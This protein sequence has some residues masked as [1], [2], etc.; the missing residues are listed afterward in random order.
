MVGE[1]RTLGS[2]VPIN[3]IHAAL[4]RTGRVLLVAGSENDATVTTY[5]ASVWDPATGT[6]ATQ[7]VPWDLFCNA[8]TFLPDGR[9]LTVGGNL[10]YNPFRGIR[11]TTVFDPS[12]GAVQ[13]ASRHGARPVVPVECRPGRRAHDDL[14]GLDGNGRHQRR[15][16]ALHG[17]RRLERGVHGAVHAA[18]LSVAAPA[19]RRARVRVRPSDRLAHLRSRDADLDHQRRPGAL[20]ERADVRLIGAPAPAS[21]SRA[22]ARGS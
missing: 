5:R 17:A 15:G 14:L 2:T 19:A 20:S 7:T 13:P 11:T 1:W 10:Q 21:G 9:V 8:M 16:R 4:L 22:I 6:F 3:P 18:A 12:D